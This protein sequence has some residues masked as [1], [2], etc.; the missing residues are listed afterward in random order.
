MK[1]YILKGNIIWCETPQRFRGIEDG[2]LVC[3]N[4]RC[5]GVFARLPEMYQGYEIEDYGDS[6]IVPGLVDLH[7][8][9]PQYPFRGLGMDMELLEWLNMNAFAEEAKYADL[10]YADKAYDIF[11]EDLLH[12]FTTRVSIFA[13]LHTEAT[14]LLMDKLEKTGLCGYVGKVNMDRNSPDILRERGAAAALIDTEEWIERCITDSHKADGGR[15][16][17]PILTPRFIPSCSDELMEGL[18]ELQRKYHLPVQSHLSEN[19]SEIAWVKELCPDSAFY[20]EAYDRFGLFGGEALT[21]MAHCIYSSPEERNLMKERNVFVAHCPE[22]NMNVSS[23]IAPI[24]QEMEEGLKIGLGSDVAGGSSLSIFRAMREAI[25]CSKLRWRIMDQAFAPLT[26]PEAFYLATK[27]GG[28][29]FGKVGSFEKDY[30]F[31]ALVLDDS[32]Y[33]HPQ[34][35]TP[36][37]RLE[38]LIYVG[39]GQMLKAKYVRGRKI[40]SC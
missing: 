4:G 10:F 17:L 8:H 9:A 19:P 14:I 30:E 40:L 31:D 36:V 24:R 7:V 37:D 11:V 35:L 21:I 28:K 18:G 34:P 13:T 6:L 16:I 3:E 38:R 22:S 39:D 15:N 5:A 25:Q 20:G 12:S 23:G 1:N 27:G 29:F 2:F 33:R 26:A 32:G